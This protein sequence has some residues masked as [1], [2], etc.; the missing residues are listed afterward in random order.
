MRYVPVFIDVSLERCVAC[1]LHNRAIPIVRFHIARSCNGFHMGVYV[2]R[3]D[4]RR[5]RRRSSHR[6]VAATSVVPGELTA[7]EQASY[8]T[9]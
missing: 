7:R 3:G 4:E 5:R 6:G 1:C 2:R 8:T 9:E